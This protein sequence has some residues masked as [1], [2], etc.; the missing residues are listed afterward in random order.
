MVVKTVLG[1]LQIM[2][3]PKTERLCEIILLGSSLPCG[4][5]E[6]CPGVMERAEHRVHWTDE[7]N[8][9]LLVSM[10]AA[11]GRRTLHVAPN[12]RGVPSMT[13]RA[14]GNR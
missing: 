13:E 10:L 5:K 11:Q 7:I 2:A 4:R 6:S 9:S 1:V 12:H 3:T 14:R 8:S